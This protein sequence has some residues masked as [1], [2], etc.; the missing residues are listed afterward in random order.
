MRTKTDI[1][2]VNR[3]VKFDLDKIPLGLRRKQSLMARQMSETATAITEDEA[4]AAGYNE[5]E[6]RAFFGAMRPGDTP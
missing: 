5:E 6:I 1:V 3:G 4:R 2:G